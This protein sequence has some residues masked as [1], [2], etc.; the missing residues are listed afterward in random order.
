[1]ILCLKFKISSGNRCIVCPAH[2]KRLKLRFTNFTH[3]KN[4]NVRKIDPISCTLY[5]QK[6]ETPGLLKKAQYG[7]QYLK[8]YLPQYLPQY[9]RRY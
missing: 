1:M 6:Q 2:P 8:Q 7:P 3:F 5:P 4:R 9:S